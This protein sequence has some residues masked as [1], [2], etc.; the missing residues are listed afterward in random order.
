MYIYPDNYNGLI[1]YINNGLK[2]TSFD[3][4]L[5]NIVALVCKL[6]LKPKCKYNIHKVSVKSIFEQI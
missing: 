2:N 4:L 5:F 3:S 6:Y 1:S